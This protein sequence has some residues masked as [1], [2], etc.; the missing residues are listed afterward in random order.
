MVSLQPGC[1]RFEFLMP[2]PLN[3][4]GG[5]MRVAQADTKNGVPTTGLHTI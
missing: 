5:V 4:A 2:S 1:T 3:N